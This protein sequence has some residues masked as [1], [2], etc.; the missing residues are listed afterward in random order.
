ML[1]DVSSRVR[2]HR[3]WS[4]L[5]FASLAAPS[6]ACSTDA[7]DPRESPLREAAP[8]VPG[9]STTPPQW[10]FVIVTRP[11]GSL[12]DAYEFVQSRIIP[13]ASAAPG[14]RGFDAYASGDGMLALVLSVA[15]WAKPT[16]NDASLL[17]HDGGATDDQIAR[18]WA[19]ATAHFDLGHTFQLDSARELSIDFSTAGTAVATP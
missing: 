8:V 1:I 16:A 17:L 19:D 3:L 10:R 18:L 2:S 11:A 4:I 15:A 14:I 5:L 6:A 9:G 13:L 7:P 12:A